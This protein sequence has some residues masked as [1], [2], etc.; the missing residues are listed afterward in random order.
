MSTGVS[1]HAL[2]RLQCGVGR[3][4]LHPISETHQL[5]PTLTYMD[6][7]ARKARRGRGGAG[8]GEDSDDGPPP[9]P[10]EPPPPPA[11]KKE[12]KPAA[13]AKEVQVAVRKADDKGVAL[14]GGL[15]AVRR[16]MLI[17]I[18]AEEDEAWED[19]EFCDGEVCFLFFLG[20]E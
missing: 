18:R 10:D 6:Y 4:H 16:E 11:A 1:G 17:A 19:Y 8:S 12:K 5:R 13:D 9:D 15:T 2:M 14:Q 7:L 3:L 20:S